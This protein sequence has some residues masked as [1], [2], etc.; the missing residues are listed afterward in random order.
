MRSLMGFLLLLIEV[1]AV[2]LS[3][4]LCILRELLLT[5]TLLNTNPLLPELHVL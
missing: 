3:L 2:Q 1:N 4:I 5:S